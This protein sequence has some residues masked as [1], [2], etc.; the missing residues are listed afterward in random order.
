MQLVARTTVIYT[1][2]QGR[3]LLTIPLTAAAT[4]HPP[5]D[6]NFH[7]RS[8]DLQM[9]LQCHDKVKLTVAGTNEKRSA[10]NWPR[11][12]IELSIESGGA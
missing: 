7:L 9:T 3:S 5:R 2:F 4:Y 1:P 8:G 11:C 6:A 12:Q 10:D